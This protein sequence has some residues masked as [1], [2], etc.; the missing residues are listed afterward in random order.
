MMNRILT[1]IYNTRLLWEV[2]D[3]LHL[4]AMIVDKTMTITDCNLSV[5]KSLLYKKEDIIGMSLYDVLILPETQ[6]L[7]QMKT[8]A[9]EGICIQKNRERFRAKVSFVKN[10]DGFIVVIEDISEVIKLEMLATHRRKEINAYNVLSSKLSRAHGLHDIIDAALDTLVYETKFDAVWICIKEEGN[11][12]C[13]FKDSTGS[14]YTSKGAL[15]DLESF[16]NKVYRAE[17]ALLVRNVLDDPRVSSDVA[18]SG[19]SS[20]AGI[21]IVTKQLGDSDGHIVGMLGVADKMGGHFSSL[22][23]HFL[24]TI[25]NLLAVAIENA[26]LISHLREKIKQIKTINEISSVA[27]SSLSIGHIFRLVFSEIKNIIDFDRASITLLNE[28]LEMLE[29]FAIDTKKPTKLTK[30][31]RAPIKETSAGWV[32]INQKPWINHDLATEMKFSLDSVLLE[33]GFRSTISVPL[34]KDRPLG[35]LNLDSTRPGNFSDHDLEILMPVS[36]HLSIALENA[37]LFEEISREKHEWEKTFDA[38]TDMV[39]IEDLKGKV[40]RINRAVIKKSGRAELSLIQ[41]P[42]QELL[43]SLQ[44]TDAEDLSPESIE[45]RRQMF[46]EIK[47][48]N[49]STYYYWTY[50]LMSSEGKIYGIVNYL[51]DVTEQKRLEQRLIRADKLASLGILAAGVAHEINN[52]LGIIAGYSEALLDRTNDPELKAVSAFE[53]F[54][55]YLETINNEIFRCK[56]ILKAL[57]DFAR[58]SG[59][60]FREIDINGLIK[61]VL[62]LVSHSAR[63]Y[64][65]N[66]ELNLQRDIPE[67]LAD[68]G[69]LRQ[70]F[71]NIIMNS[72]HFMG[73]Q[74]RIV[75]STSIEKALFDSDYI[76]ISI[77]DNGKGIER[78]IIDKIF[79]PFFS[80]KAVGEGTGLGLAIC[81]RIVSEHEGTID[82]ESRP[83]KGATF[84]VRLPVRKKPD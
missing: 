13:R 27:N 58:P 74:G 33:E 34:F 5:K 57:L 52:P 15:K 45:H 55:E 68:A 64:K 61:E 14:S 59:R 76:K 28:D 32:T 35:A 70:V 78:E 72:F 83:G 56:D 77:S 73:Q 37:L 82:V 11:E 16:I 41:K 21:P 23:I 50:P 71:L 10:Q 18:R 24:T 84:I 42:S 47:G 6:G 25:G 2:L 9:Y 19:Y 31:V 62:L 26:R 1:E 49:G 40:L 4:P 17:R 60:T 48:T 63:S 30:G 29:I 81:H 3:A 66:I 80:T 53:D 22:D 67:T 36:K 39:W 65:H 43:R 20:I 46:K 54:P 79:D 38:I 69:S 51:K 12:I 7:N 44:I 75:I 8:I